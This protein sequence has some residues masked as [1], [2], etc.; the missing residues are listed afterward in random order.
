MTLPRL[1]HLTEYWIDNPPTYISMSAVLRG[2]AGNPAKG[3]KKKVDGYVEQ[4]IPRDAKDNPT[5]DV[6]TDIL[7]A[8]RSFGGDVIR[9][10]K[11]TPWQ[12]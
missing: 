3:R 11:K 2:L 12:T 10:P 8:A 1:N 9:P 6:P 7:S 4:N 5:K